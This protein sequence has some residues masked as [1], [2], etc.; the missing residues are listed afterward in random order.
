MVAGDRGIRA[1]S[2]RGGHAGKEQTMD[3]GLNGK[4]ALVAASSKGLGKASALALAREGA[5]VTICARHLAGLETAAAEIRAATGAEVLAVPADLATPAGIRDVMVAANDR[6][7][8]VDVLVDNSGGPAIGRFADLTDEDWVRAFEVVTL[9][10]VRFVREVVPHMRAQGWGR[11]VAIQSMSVKQPVANI[12]LS[13]GTRPGVAGL[14]KAL[15]PDL[16]RDGITINLV[17]P[18]SF[19]TDRILGSR[20]AEPSEATADRLAAAAAAIPVGRLGEP[21]ELGSL[22]AFLA[23]QQAAYITGA[24]YQIDG[25]VIR[26]NL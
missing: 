23:S 11:I 26:S 1:D 20:G 17:L 2:G 22:V 10:F 24:V 8:G 25:G 15:M 7:G 12:D 21:D 9:N 13:N 4:V 5:R 3:L 19:R 18:G 6:F 14:M 16:A